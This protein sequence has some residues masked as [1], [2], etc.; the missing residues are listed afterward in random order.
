MTVEKQRLLT[1]EAMREF[2]GKVVPQEIYLRNLAIGGADSVNKRLWT[3]RLY[4][5]IPVEFIASKLELQPDEYLQLEK[6]GTL[7]SS[8]VIEKLSSLFAI[9]IEWFLCRMPMYPILQVTS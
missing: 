9:P 4:L 5:N 6:N 3:L 2:V 1:L 7:V 8:E